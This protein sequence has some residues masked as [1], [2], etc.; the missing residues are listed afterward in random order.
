MTTKYCMLKEQHMLFKSGFRS[1][2]SLARSDIT[3]HYK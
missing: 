1:R 2:R 3:K